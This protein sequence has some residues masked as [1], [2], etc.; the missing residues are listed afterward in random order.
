[1][2]QSLPGSISGWLFLCRHHGF[3]GRSAAGAS[4]PTTVESPVAPCVMLSGDFVRFAADDHAQIVPI[5]RSTSSAV[6]KLRVRNVTP[7]WIR[8]QI[9]AGQRGESNGNP[10]PIK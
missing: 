2:A 8:L 9:G 10:Q 7:R 6:D 1:M 5:F 3:G 4:V